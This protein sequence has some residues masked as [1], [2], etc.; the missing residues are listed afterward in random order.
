M[1]YTLYQRDK[2]INVLNYEKLTTSTCKDELI[3]V[4]IELCQ[5]DINKLMKTNKRGR[6][7]SFIQDNELIIRSCDS[8]N[9]IR[10]FKVK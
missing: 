3:V 6:I 2:N 7:Q 4:A 1:T 5:D 8:K 10:A 9:I